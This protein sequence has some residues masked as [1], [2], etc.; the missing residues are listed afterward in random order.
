MNAV[1]RV[2]FDIR[3][4]VAAE[5]KQHD[6]S[7]DYAVPE[8]KDVCQIRLEVERAKVRANALDAARKPTTATS[9]G[10]GARTPGDR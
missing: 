9:A 6:G 10:A 4:L 3:A 8:R 2:L 5:P 7:I 1:S